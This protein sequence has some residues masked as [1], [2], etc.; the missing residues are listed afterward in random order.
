MT[1]PRKPRA[2]GPQ[3]LK[4]AEA[5]VTI[6][7]KRAAL[8][9][10]AGNNRRFWHLRQ[11]YFGSH[12]ARCIATE[13]AYR[14]F[15]V[16]HRKGLK[17]KRMAIASSLSCVASPSEPV[18]IL[19]I[20]KNDDLR[21]ICSFGIENRARQYMVERFITAVCSTEPSQ[22]LMRGGVP[23]AIE[24]IKKLLAD[25]YNYAIEADLTKC[26]PSMNA[27]GMHEIVPLPKEVIDKVV[28]GEEYVPIP[29]EALLYYFGSSNDDEGNPALLM[30]KV[31]EALRGIPHGSPASSAVAEVLI[32]HVL[33]TLPNT[34][35]VPSYAD[36][37]LIMAK[38]EEAAE[39]IYKTMRSAFLAHP[40]GPLTPKIQGRFKPGEPIS[41]LGHVLTQTNS[42][43]SI[44]PTGKNEDKFKSRYHN[45]MKRIG[46]GKLSLTKRKEIADEISDYVHTWCANFRACDE[47]SS[48]KTELVR[49][50]D[51][52]LNSK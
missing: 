14:S 11:R 21:M 46:D 15:K 9:Y 38:T 29:G 36:N 34:V 43:I 13:K 7:L 8:A 22:F 23:A 28:M 37:M 26:F 48:R 17:S 33:R 31:A 51:K 6:L 2:F 30:E 3:H 41:F 18:T 47:M 1:N 24:Q 39:S 50:I 27:G 20:P 35:M 16:R 40:A 12:D 49:K 32:A 52:C 4:K 10:A 44:R 42:K 19:G 25:G 5:E 45:A